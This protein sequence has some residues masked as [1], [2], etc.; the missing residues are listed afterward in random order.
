MKTP[1][2]DF[3]TECEEIKGDGFNYG[4]FQCD[5]GNNIEGDG[6]D[7]NGMI[8]DGFDCSGGTNLT[9]DICW[10]NQ[11]PVSWISLVNADNEVYL[12]FSEEVKQISELNSTSVSI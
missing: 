8:E 9:P 7:K 3:A 2:N 6:C 10:D 1:S 11:K 12:E 5:D 4:Q